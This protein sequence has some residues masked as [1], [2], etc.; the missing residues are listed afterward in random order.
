G[1]LYI[2]GRLKELIVLANAIKVH[3]SIV[4]KK[5]ETSQLVKHCVVY[6]DEHPF[7]VALIVPVKA[8]ED[9]LVLKEEIARINQLLKPHERVIKFFIAS[10]SFFQ[11]GNRVSSQDKLHRKRIIEE[12]RT[13]LE[14]LYLN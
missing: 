10:E 13:E 3:P 5:M 7:L 12:Y 1:Y 4:E 14:N 2:N 8:Q 6:G 11:N 9:R